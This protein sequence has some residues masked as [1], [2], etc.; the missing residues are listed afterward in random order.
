MPGQ[1][2]VVKLASNAT[3]SSERIIRER[4][5]LRILLGDAFKNPPRIYEPPVGAVSVDRPLEPTKQQLAASLGSAV[6]DLRATFRAA[7]NYGLLSKGPLER[8]PLT[9]AVA[10]QF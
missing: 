7:T 1:K 3:D 9:A 8:D 2:D 5:S 4:E 6:A 10:E